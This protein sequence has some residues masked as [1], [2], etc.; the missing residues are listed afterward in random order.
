MRWPCTASGANVDPLVKGCRMMGVL[1]SQ[2]FYW[3]ILG[4]NNKHWIK[5]KHTRTPK[6]TWFT[7]K[8]KKKTSNWGK[9]TE[10]HL[11]ELQVSLLHTLS[12]PFS[13][14]HITEKNHFLTFSHNLKKFILSPWKKSPSKR[15]LYSS[16]T[17]NPLCCP[18]CPNIHINTPRNLGLKQP[19]KSTLLSF[20]TN[21]RIHVLNSSI[22]RTCFLL[23]KCVKASDVFYLINPH[24]P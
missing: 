13:H 14:T 20:C 11:E 3:R 17:L 21:F 8:K 2:P 18:R 4:C 9:I 16:Y 7:W 12:Q 10:P 22:D 1:G 23:F 5:G 19:S 24:L 6:N 15:K